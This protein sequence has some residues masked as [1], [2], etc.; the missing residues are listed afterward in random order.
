MQ[1]IEWSQFLEK[2]SSLGEKPSAVT[3][4]IFDGVH[5]GHKALIEQV[6]SKKNNAVPVII[7]F[8]QN[9]HKKVSGH[10]NA[11]DLLS[12]RQ[13]I[14][15]YESLGVSLTVVIEF[16]ESFRRMSGREFL[17]KLYEHGKMSFMA[18]GGNFRCGYLLDTDAPMIRQMNAERNI[19]TFIVQPLT[20]NG[21]TISSSLIR[22][23]IAR[24]KLNKAAVLLG[25]SFTVDLYGASV[26]YESASPMRKAGS[27]SIAYDIA[28]RGGIL[29]P[30][31]KYP[32]LLLGKDC[33]RTNGK[34]AEILIEGGSIIIAGDFERFC[35]EYVEF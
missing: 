15:V 6:V 22:S 23:V 5:R 27:Y 19:S 2:D 18:V 8:K 25:R 31:G 11:G 29:P 12:F 9:N 17:H 35:P 24:G 28:G 1:V 14:A 3:V 30:P 20:E 26:S 33:D 13:K 16:T 4:G 32:V 10:E 21:H 7:T 34:P